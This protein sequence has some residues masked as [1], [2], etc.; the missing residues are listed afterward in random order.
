MLMGKCRDLFE[1]IFFSNSSNVRKVDITRD[2][3][4]TRER[5]RK[6]ENENEKKETKGENR[7]RVLHFTPRAQQHA[8]AIYLLI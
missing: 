6:N 4:R 2:T 8:R 7:R 1:L 3:Q 5:E